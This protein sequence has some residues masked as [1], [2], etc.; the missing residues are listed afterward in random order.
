MGTTIRNHSVTRPFERPNPIDVG[1]GFWPLGVSDVTLG[2]LGRTP[3][4]RVADLSEHITI[5][6]MKRSGEIVF[7][8]AMPDDAA[9][10]RIEAA[11][12]A[13]VSF[14]RARRAYYRARAKRLSRAKPPARQE[15]AR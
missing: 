10:K 7:S 8:P 4:A 11:V 14:K 3:Y 2:I 12:A 5:V 1:P 13:M 15:A 6:S 9:R